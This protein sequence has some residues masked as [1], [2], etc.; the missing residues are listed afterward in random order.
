MTDYGR[1]QELA[2][3]LLEVGID[4]S[5]LLGAG[6]DVASRA[7]IERLAAI[8][9]TPLPR[10]GDGTS[11]TISRLRAWARSRVEQR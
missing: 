10:M 9:F 7:I 5:D 4:T 1:H 3:A 6:V 2:E 8:G 11:E